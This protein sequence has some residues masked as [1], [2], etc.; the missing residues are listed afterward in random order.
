METLL[1]GDTPYDI[2]SARQA[3]VQTVSVRCGGWDDV[4]LDRAVAI[5]VDPADLLA[6][7]GISPFAK[8]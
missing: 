3:G 5:D 2:E 7:F 6:R 8:A 1:L 4:D